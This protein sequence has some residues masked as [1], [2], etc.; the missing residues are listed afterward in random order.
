[1]AATIPAITISGKNP[2]RILWE[3]FQRK[4]SLNSNLK[5]SRFAV[6]KR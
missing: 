5:Y 4:E 2:S 6:L 1:M 3:I